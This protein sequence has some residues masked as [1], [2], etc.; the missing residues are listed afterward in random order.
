MEKAMFG[1]GCFWCVEDEFRNL[2]GVISATSGYSGG[3]I[4][5]PTYEDVCTDETGHA[6]VIL[7]EFDSKMISF[8]KLVD[9]FWTMHDPTTLNRQGPDEGTQYRSGIYYFNDDQKKS[10]ER[11]KKK[12]D[13]SGAFSNPIVTEIMP[14]AEFYKAEEYH[15]QYFCKMREKQIVR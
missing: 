13:E 12:M 2:P 1:A 4:K 11:A 6:E 14:A 7:V 8:E 9:F 10:A 5:N 15:Q 3:H